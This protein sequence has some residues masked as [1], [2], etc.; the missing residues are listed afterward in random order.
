MAR[1]PFKLKLKRLDFISA[2]DAGAQGPI[3]NVA[4]I[5]RADPGGFEATFRVAKT[6]ESLGLVFGWAMAGSLDGGKTPHV[7]YQ[8]DAIDVTSDEFIKVCAEFMEGGASADVMHDGEQDGRVVF[9]FPLVPEINKALGIETSTHGLAIAMKPSPETFK[10]FQSGELAAFSIGGIGERTALKRDG[11]V[12][13]ASLYTNEVDGHAHAIC[14]YDDGSL[15]VEYATMAGVEYGHSHGIVR[16]EDGT[17]TILA[18]SGHTHELAAGQPG[19]VVVPE[20]T[21]VVVS[22]DAFAPEAVA[23]RSPSTI[24][25]SAKSR[26]SESSLS[27]GGRNVASMSTTEAEKIA[28]LEKRYE[29]I[30]NLSA[31]EFTV[32]K[33]LPVTDREAFLAKSHADRQ[34]AIESF[35]K[36]NAVEYTADNGTVYRKSDDPR[37]V[38]LAKQADAANRRANEADLAKRATETLGGASDIQRAIVKA[39]EAIKDGTEREKATE[40][41]KG[42]VATSRIDKAADG[43]ASDDSDKPTGPAAEFDALTEKYAKDNNVTK[44]AARVAVMKTPEGRRL[45]NESVRA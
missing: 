26:A 33:S 36:A 12:R 25:P 41:I 34:P 31:T 7:D 17:L 9:A 1:A 30:S 13:K 4:L 6:D 18:D 20:N 29:R 15:R 14:V 43:F 5:K 40:Y 10:R 45:Y 27:S 19:L 3:A 21:I 38:D 22:A 37:L 23:M 24:A 28:E 44:S 8:D 2:V 39:I 16:G 42:L 32:W 11:R 35:E